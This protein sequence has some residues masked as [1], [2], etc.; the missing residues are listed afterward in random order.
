MSNIAPAAPAEPALADQLLER[1][2]NSVL[3]AFD[4]YAISLGD[5]LGYYRALLEH[6]PQTAGELAVNA[7]ADPR[8]TR[9]WLEQQAVTGIVEV[10][11]ESDDDERRVYRLPEAYADVLVNP[12]SLST[13]VPMARLLTDIGETK[14]AP[15][16][17]GPSG[18]NSSPARAGFRLLHRAGD[19]AQHVA[20]LGADGRG[21]R[22]E[23]ELVLDR[24]RHTVDDGQRVAG[25]P[26]L[27]AG[28][29][30]AHRGRAG[31]GPGRHLPART[32]AAGGADL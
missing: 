24:D 31:L 2:F 10:A 3:A 6:G 22:G 23:V 8:Y 20:D 9:E 17:R 15:A 4:V 12:T 11:V 29:R 32:Q 7:G 14:F 25:G 13:G 27:G 28:R 5:R 19:V 26:S 30:G 1:I 21:V 18:A 16:G